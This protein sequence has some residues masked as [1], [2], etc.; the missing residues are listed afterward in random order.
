MNKFL[1]ITEIVTYVKEELKE[2]YNLDF[3]VE[4]KYGDGK[5]FGIEVAF[6]VK[7]L[8]LIKS[9]NSYFITGDDVF[10]LLC[11]H[12]FTSELYLIN[13]TSDFLYLIFSNEK[14]GKK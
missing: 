8:E 2:K 1:K 9:K 5:T 3:Q 13:T 12:G 7:L 10:N 4:E 14:K 11:K 6:P